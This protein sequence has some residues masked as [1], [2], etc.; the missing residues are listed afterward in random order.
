MRIQ[1]ESTVDAYTII[2]LDG[3]I[4]TEVVRSGAGVWEILGLMRVPRDVIRD[5][6]DHLG[7]QPSI[8]I[9]F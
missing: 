8:Q 3:E 4:A 9:T 5:V 6:V 2:D 7:Q 1:I